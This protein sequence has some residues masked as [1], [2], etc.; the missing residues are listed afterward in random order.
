MISFRELTEDKGGKNLHLEHL[1]DEIIN[2]GVDGGR[3]ALNFLRSLRDMLAGSSRSSVNMTVKWDGAPAIFAGIDPSDNKFFVAKKSVFNVNPK[4]YKK[5]AEIDD[6]LS[7]TLNSKFKI[8]LQEFSKLGIKGVLQ[9][10]LMFTDDV[11]TSKIEGVLYYTFQ[12][13]TIVYAVPV[14]SKLGNIIKKSKIGIVW[15]TTYTGNALEDMKASFGVNI[16]GLK[17][18]SSV[19]MDDATY[20]DTAG[21]STFT[22]TETEKVTAILSNVGKTF[23]RINGP[24][25]RKFI[26]LQE[27]MTGAIAGASLKTYN[28]SKVRAGEKIKQPSQHAK[29][30]EKWVEISIQK[31]IDK[32]KSPAGKKKYE[33]VQKEYMREVRKY[34]GMLVQVIT[35]QNLLVDAKMVIVK[36]LNSVKG[37][38]DTFIKTANGFKVTNPEGY[39]AIDRVSGGAVKLVDR[40]EFSF[41]NFTAIKAWDK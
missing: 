21:K 16:S 40:M 30:Y 17:S 31:Q 18:P 14:D 24:Q 3:A 35:F 9:G 23:Q 27:S 41:N 6:D 10:D 38:T 12:P 22:S 2:Y 4:L 13:N 39:V 33:N 19:W 11:E 5:E 34:T 25:L 36:K 32:V 20:K 15:H 37:L 8:A 1:E 26:A 28:N 29:G 7:G